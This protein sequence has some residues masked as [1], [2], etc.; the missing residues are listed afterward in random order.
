VSERP[1]GITHRIERVQCATPM[2]QLIGEISRHTKHKQH[3]RAWITR[4]LVRSS[5]VSSNSGQVVVCV[6]LSAIVQHV[7]GDAST[8]DTSI[9]NTSCKL[10][11]LSYFVAQ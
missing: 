10:Q 6:G 7:N 8:S 11:L 4:L 1:L 5:F 3:T 2:S 9:V